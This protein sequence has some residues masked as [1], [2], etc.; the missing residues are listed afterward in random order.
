MIERRFTKSVS[1]RQGRRQLP[2][3]DVPE[4]P[5][6]EDLLRDDLDLPEVSELQVIRHFTNLSTKNYAIDKGFYPLGS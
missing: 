4:T 2:D 1:R 3:V 6:P 5:L